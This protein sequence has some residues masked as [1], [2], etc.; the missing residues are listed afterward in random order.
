MRPRIQLGHHLDQPTKKLILPHDSLSR[1]MHLVGA[2]GAGKT[3]AIHAL[4]RPLMMST[5]RH[6]SSLFVFDLMG[7]LSRD[8]LHWIASKHCPQHVRDR[9]LYIEPAK[10]EY[11]LPFNPLHHVNEENRYYHVSRAVDL[12]LR[13]WAAQDLSLQPRLMQWSYKAVTA[14]AA[15]EFPL[16]MT[17][18]LLHPGTEEHKRILRMIP[19]DIQMQWAEILNHRGNDAV[20]ILESTR[21]RF[22]P[23]YGA[24]QTKRMFGTM[25]SRLDVES[26]IRGRR[27]VILNLAQLGKLPKQLGSTIG[28]LILN[29]VLE[30]VFNMSV[31]YGREAVEPTYCLLDEFQQFSASHDIEE[32]LPTCRQMGLRLI[33][34]HQSFSQLKQQEIDLTS[35]IWQARNRLMF[36][37]SA[38]DADIIA[39]ELATL[40]FNR[41]EV[42]DLRMSRRQLISGYRTEWL[43]SMGKSHS[44]SR[45]EID[46]RSVGYSRGENESRSPNGRAGNKGTNS[47]HNHSHVS[48]GSTANGETDTTSWSQQRV[49]I[50]DNFEEVSNVTYL[51]FEEHRLEWMKKIRQLETG[52]AVGKFVDDS[53]L[54]QLMIRHRPVRMTKVL[55]KRVEE[56]LQRNF[57]QDVF[58]SS[59]T[60]DQLAEQ[61]RI[62]LMTHEVIALPDVS[63]TSSA[64]SSSFRTRKRK[65]DK[66]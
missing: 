32:A 42:K 12:I 51:S 36:A 55:E 10:S 14:V 46:Q 19:D 50:H 58:I 37:N 54:Y 43:Q 13:A 6:K 1:H 35:M 40:S 57:E 47:G 18:Y 30:T 3:V 20:K 64:E 60:A 48:G 34:A 45:S 22:D 23:I 56:L 38:E 29:E 52:Q 16:A 44:H 63:G 31:K 27:I 25:Q 4:M 53:Y 59:E 5:G 17:R 11:V 28:S 8:L 39:N 65:L 41:M 33:L 15:L 21:N 62:R 26:L 61:E 66:S 49:P 7:N 24:P 9:L 2:T